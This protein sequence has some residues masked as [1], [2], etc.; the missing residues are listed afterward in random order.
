MSIKVLLSIKPEYAEKILNGE[1]KFEFR[2]VLPKNKE[3]D[4]VVIYAT[5]PIGKIIGEFEIADFISESPIQLWQLTEEFAGISFHFFE[6]YFSD[7]ELAHAIKVGK[8]TRYNTAKKLTDVL[9]SGVPPQSF[10]YL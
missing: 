6:S 3:V 7:R 2:R 8:V 9:P 10:C 5:M 4:K 1:K